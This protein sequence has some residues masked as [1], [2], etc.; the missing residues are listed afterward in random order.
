MVT[1]NVVARAMADKKIETQRTQRT[2]REEEM[3]AIFSGILSAFFASSAF[4]KQFFKKG[5]FHEL[6]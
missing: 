6:E 2:R 5:D 4:L 1:G 3:K